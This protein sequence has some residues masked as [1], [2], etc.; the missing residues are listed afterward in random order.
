MQDHI[1]V[2]QIAKVSVQQMHSRLNNV[3]ILTNYRERFTERLEE[4][5]F[6][7]ITPVKTGKKESEE[8]LLKAVLH[9]QVV[10]ICLALYAAEAM[11]LQALSEALCDE[12]DAQSARE[13]LLR[14]VFHER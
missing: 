2:Q 7:Q 4:L 10:Y 1:P 14:I 8:I 3:I 11:G 13:C 12:C 9:R 6:T 5:G